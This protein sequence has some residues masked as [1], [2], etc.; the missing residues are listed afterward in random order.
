M[1]L[2]SLFGRGPLSEKRIAKISKLA[3]NPYAQPDVRMR[4]MHRL[5]QDGSPAALRGL[6]KRFST[7]A[8]GHIADEDEK[9]FLED[10]LVDIGEE[11]LGPLLEYI[12][13]DK[14]LTYAMRAYKRIAGSAR[15]VEA[16]ALVLQY[17]G[18]EDHRALEAK[19]QLVLQLAEDLSDARVLPALVPFLLDHSDDV[20]WAV[21]ELLEKAADGRLITPEVQTE[22]GRV[23]G[24]IVTGTEAST[25][26]LRRTA[27]LLSTREWPVGGEREALPSVI[28]DEYFL[29]KKRFVRRRVKKAGP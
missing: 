13:S 4:E 24:E 8:S 18:P 5:I 20:R 17:H 27:E 10:A 29:D 28:D 7:N 3:C 15:A 22:I 6:I 2:M 9:K 26:I 16:F 11:A 25:R 21:L 23:L 1:G 14:Q 19:L 12:K